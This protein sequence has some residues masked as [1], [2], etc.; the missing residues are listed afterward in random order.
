[1]SNMSKRKRTRKQEKEQERKEK[2]KGKKRRAREQESK[3]ASEKLAGRERVEVHDEREGRG[4]TKKRGSQSSGHPQQDV[5]RI[6]RH[7]AL[8]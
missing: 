1:M 3:T 7:A 4:T 2:E 5:V 8:V 6:E